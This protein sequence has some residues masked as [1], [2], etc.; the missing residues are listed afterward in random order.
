M[1]TGR[2]SL[3]HY[4]LLRELCDSCRREVFHFVPIGTEPATGKCRRCGGE[5]GLADLSDSAIYRL[6]AGP[7]GELMI[8]PVI[9]PVAKTA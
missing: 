2:L 9:A 6:I 4:D 7:D 8:V 3:V 5:T 1:A